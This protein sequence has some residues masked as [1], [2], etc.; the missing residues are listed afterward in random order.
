MS[1]ST[2][3][4]GAT[5]SFG[6]AG[7]IKSPT[8]NIFGSL[9]NGNDSKGK[10]NQN[11]TS[12]FSF[13]L[14]SSTTVTPIAASDSAK[15]TEQLIKAENKTESVFGN[16]TGFAFG[17]EANNFS[18][19]ALAAKASEEKKSEEPFPTNDGLSFAALAQNSNSTPLN[20]SKPTTAPPPGGFFGLSH[21]DT[22]S[23]LMSP[24]SSTNTA[25]HTPNASATGD[26]NEATDENYDPHYEPIIALP[27]EIHVS[28]GE[29]D[30]KKLFSE[31]SKLYRYDGT[32]KEW[33]ERGVGEL[34]VLHHAANNSY[35]LLLRREQ[36]HK[37]VL[38]VALS[39]DFQINPMKQSDKAYCWVA[40]NFAEDQQ[41][42]ELESLSV[43]FKN[44]G[45][46]NN[47]YETVL[48]CINQLKSRAELEPEED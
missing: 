32:N 43:R 46:A 10:E 47:F 44:A 3:V 45:L 14:P 20:F 7:I 21:R 27:D 13:A 23:N 41:N 8:T 6:S 15:P 22:F 29:E 34:K 2:P 24:N 38:N 35:R 40:Q 48:D 33:K 19:A 1:T 42:G 11:P 12:K 31:R 25:N 4:F 37:L 18:F 9:Q 26:E 28:T 30:E 39:T 36:I 5:P 16:S 17:G